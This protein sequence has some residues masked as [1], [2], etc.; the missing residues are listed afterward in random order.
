MHSYL[1]R[2]CLYSL[3]IYIL[4]GR[5]ESSVGELEEGQPGQDEGVGHLQLEQ[6]V[7]RM[8][9]LELELTEAREAKGRLE[10][11]V[12]WLQEELAKAREA[13]GKLERM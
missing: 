2:V 13:K 12:R 5:L 8:G 9:A 3:C 7:S 4:Y 6:G 11:E 1:K 10:G